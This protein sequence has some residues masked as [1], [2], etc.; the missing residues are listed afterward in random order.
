MKNQKCRIYGRFSSK[1][2][3]RGDSERRQIE[4]A[5]KYAAKHGLTVVGIYFDEGVSGKSGANLENEF[6]RLLADAQ[7]GEILL[8]EIL[9]RIGR[10]NPFVLGKLIFDTV[11]RGVEVRAWEEGKIINAENID[12]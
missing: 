10:Q 7:D 5:K 3:E 8:V 12:Q 6:G 2:Q 4:G 1:P 9:D 11:S